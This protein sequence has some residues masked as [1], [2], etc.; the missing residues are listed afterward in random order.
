VPGPLSITHSAAVE[1]AGREERR[2]EV[3]FADRLD[4][5]QRAHR[6]A[7]FPLAVVYKFIDDQGS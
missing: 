6:W 7:A 4:V 5:F 2:P 1:P 3:S